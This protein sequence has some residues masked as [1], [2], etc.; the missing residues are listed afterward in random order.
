MSDTYM[1][2]IRFHLGP[3]HLNPK[4]KSVCSLN[5]SF[6]IGTT[7]SGSIL[8][9]NNERDKSFFVNKKKIK[10]P[11]ISHFN[12]TNTSGKKNCLE[13]GENV[14]FWYNMI[15]PLLFIVLH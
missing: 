2:P 10:I 6:T 5:R 3:T 7:P 4:I 11:L 1:T 15:K 9:R 14:L 12:N 13:W 8:Q